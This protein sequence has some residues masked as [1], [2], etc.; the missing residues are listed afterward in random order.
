MSLREGVR[1]PLNGVNILYLNNL[2][3]TKPHTLVVKD[4]WA[5][6]CGRN[7][8]DLQ[9]KTGAGQIEKGTPS[10]RSWPRSP[11]PDKLLGR[12][13]LVLCRKMECE[14]ALC[15]ASEP[16]SYSE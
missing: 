12:D 14:C 7:R 13:L 15:L 8:Y 5:S 3:I 11:A 6:W 1:L 9:L 10:S 2:L 4:P 16:L